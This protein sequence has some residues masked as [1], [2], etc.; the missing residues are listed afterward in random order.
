MTTGI[1]LEVSQRE[2]EDTGIFF[3]PL[4]KEELYKGRVK[5]DNNLAA[6]SAFPHMDAGKLWNINL[7]IFSVPQL[8]AALSLQFPRKCQL[9]HAAAAGGGFFRLKGT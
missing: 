7:Q 3:L 8:P 1:T 4:G 9:K 2:E 5:N 6:P